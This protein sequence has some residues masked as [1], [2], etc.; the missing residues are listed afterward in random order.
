MLSEKVN[1]PAG[2][3][4]VLQ[5]ATYVEAVKRRICGC[6]K[7]CL[8][9]SRPGS[10]IAREAHGTEVTSCMHIPQPMLRHCQGLSE[11]E[12]AIYLCILHTCHQ[13]VVIVGMSKDT[14]LPLKL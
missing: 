14:N 13:S 12:E 3:L 7:C 10:L 9:L 4:H 5:G 11:G 8:C 2:H 1:K 6:N